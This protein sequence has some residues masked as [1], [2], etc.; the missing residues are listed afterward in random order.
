[1]CGK[2]LSNGTGGSLV[3]QQAIVLGHTQCALTISARRFALLGMT[4]E[5]VAMAG[6]SHIFLLG[7]DNAQFVLFGMQVLLAAW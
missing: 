7:L 2:L 6:P 3:E 5:Q 1:M 4:L